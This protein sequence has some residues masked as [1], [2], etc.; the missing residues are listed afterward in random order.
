M[1]ENKSYSKLKSASA[2]FNAMLR[3]FGVVTVMNVKIYD[4]L[5]DVLDGTHKVDAILAT[6]KEATPIAEIDTLKIANI[7]VEGPDK[8]VTGGQYNNPLIKFGKSARLEMQDALGHAEALE[9]LS[10]VT[11]EHFHT[12]SDDATAHETASNDVLHVTEEFAGPKTIIGQTFF[13]DSE[14]GAQIPAYILIY[15]FLPDSF[16]NLT[17]DA[18]GDA[19]V[20]DF[21]GDLNTVNI[22]VGDEGDADE[23]GIVTGVFYSI[24]STSEIPAVA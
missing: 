14:T 21:N 5:N 11:L 9:A 22:L 18:E 24:L 20:F 8:T 1:P 16:F 6:Y 12:L 15:E 2:A 10:G 7:T 23:G 13:I 17:Q 19:T 3:H 4:Q